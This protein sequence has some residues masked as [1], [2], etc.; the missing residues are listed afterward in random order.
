MQGS[1]GGSWGDVQYDSDG[2]LIEYSS[3]SDDSSGSL[4]RDEKERVQE[5]RDKA[6]PLR[7]S[8]RTISTQLHE[9]PTKSP[10]RA[11]ARHSQAGSSKN[12]P[13]SI[14]S[15]QPTPRSAEPSF[16]MPTM[17]G[18]IS[19]YGDESPLRNSEYRR[20]K[21]RQA[22]ERKTPVSSPRLSSQRSLKTA[23]ARQDQDLGPWYYVYAVYENLILPLLA[24]LWDVF[25]YAN[26]HFL[27]PILGFALGVG[28]IAI[29]LQ[30]ASGF[31]FSR[32]NAA[33]APFC[34]IP[35]SSYILP[36]CGNHQHDSQANF[37]D[38]IN[39]QSH[40]EDILDASKDT[41][42]LPATIKDSEIAIR[43][44]RTLVKHS[45]LPS[46]NQLDLEF[47]N[48]VLTAKEAATDLSRYNTRI[49]STIDRVIATNT[50]TMAVLQG[51]EENEASRGSLARVFNAVT[52]AF[53]SPPATLQQRIF[54]QYVLH[55]SR[56]KEEIT[57]LIETAQAL[58]MILNNLDERLDTIYSI[59]VNDDQTISRNQDELLS[60][61]WTRLGGNSASVKA[62]NRQLNL[63][64]NI[65]QYRK[66]AVKHVSE[67]L[68]KLHEIQAELE[69]LRDG[70]AAPEVLGWR[71]GIPISYHVE[72]VEKGVERLRIARGENMRVEGEMYR[73]RI[74]ASEGEQVMRELPDGRSTTVVTVNA[75]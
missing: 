53:I 25:S 31:V 1:V 20:R 24:Y 34:L 51:I 39:V 54:D 71:Q 36:M 48:F 11:N 46:R 12:T 23:T 4:G 44:L 15:S 18:S 27:K 5:N 47:H 17:N 61:L 14:K 58:L 60:S 52:G 68:L 38:L 35:G 55:V 74:R 41:S 50:W 29:G 13:R 28:V 6:T 7:S 33:L 37:E 66:K 45:R 22:S 2:D 10:D 72:L 70:V 26:R 32:F 8:I 40:F 43:D 62:N 42:A 49:G 73:S 69:N 19:P 57:G 67:T 75:K 3:E 59:T 63:L 21:Q 30:L 56:N 64:K 65:S 16:I 9:T